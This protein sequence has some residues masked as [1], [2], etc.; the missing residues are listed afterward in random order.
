MVAALFSLEQFWWCHP[1]T[2]GVTATA[3]SALKQLKQVKLTDKIVTLKLDNV[4]I[5]KHANC[6]LLQ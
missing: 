5:L 2:G 3:I 6:I 4:S 1:I